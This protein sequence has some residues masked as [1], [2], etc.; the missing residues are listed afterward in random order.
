MTQTCRETFDDREYQRLC[1]DILAARTAMQGRTAWRI[2]GTLREFPKFAPVN[3]WFDYPVHHVD[4]IGVLADV[5]PD[6]DV[7]LWKKAAEKRKPPGDKRKERKEAIETAY[8]ACTI[9]GDVTVE[10][11]AEYMGVTEKTVRNRIKEHGD[12]WVDEGKV[13]RKSQGK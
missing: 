7:P 2:E 12:F 4:N 13:G 11:M 5:E 8:S 10:A 9:D 1:D 6:G 3:L